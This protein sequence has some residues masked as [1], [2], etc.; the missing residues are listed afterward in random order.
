MFDQS[1]EKARR[2]QRSLPTF[3]YH[4][5]FLELL[6]FIDT[7]YRHV[8]TP[9]HIALNGAFRRLEPSPQR[10]Y[11]RLVNRKGRIFA[12]N[13]LRYPEIGDLNSALDTLR[14]DDWVGSPGGE[15]FED[16]LAFLTKDEI[17]AGLAAWF[18]GMRRSLRKAELIEFAM[19]NCAPE[20]FMTRVSLD[21]L[22]VQRQSDWVAFL[23][24]LYFG[25]S[26]DSLSRFTLRDMGLVRTHSF[27]EV[28]EPRFA[29]REEAL[30][31]FFYSSRLRRYERGSEHD[32]QTV[33]TTIDEWPEPAYEGAAGLRDRL[34][35]AIGRDLERRGKPE[36]ARQVYELGDS[37]ACTERGIRLLLAA[38]DRDEAQRRLEA[39]LENPRS[40][41]ERLLAS[42]LL[43]RKFG[44][45]RTSVVTDALRA[46][47]TIE[48][49]EAH[50]GA[51]DRGAIAHCEQRG[52]RAWRAENTLWRTLFGL[53][54]W[55]ELFPPGQAAVHSPF[56]DAPGSLADGS[57]Y[58]DNE[59]AIEQ[60]LAGLADTAATKRRLLK[61]STR[62]FGTANGIFRWRRSMAEVVFALIDHAEPAPVA[63][64][65]R[66][67]SQRYRDTRDGF[68]DL[69]VVDDG[70]ARLVEIKAQGDQLRRN[71]LN[72][73]QQLRDAGLNAEIV[74]VRWILDP[75]QTYVVVDVETTGGRGEAHRITELAAVKLRGD[76]VVDRFQSLVNPL[77]A[78]PRGIT[79]LTGITEE[80]VNGAPRFADLADD[81]EAFMDDA[82]FVAHNVN[83]DYGFVSREY[84]RLGR[85][86][87]HAK[88]CTCASM[89]KLYPG[90]DS[91]SL[92]ALCQRFDIPLKTHHRALCDAE[93]AAELLLL[94][95]EKRREALA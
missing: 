25:E 27:R 79:R 28:Y 86:F 70:G 3:Y 90:G 50:A 73:L 14:A 43:A 57:F 64:M 92:A 89:R 31:T 74:R 91:Y 22:L 65:L 34:A 63:A 9:A 21:R 76:Q 15:F 54:F 78:I 72:R 16:V 38:G 67:M 84:A 68:P 47:A 44:K 69:L 26:R 33:T 80:M 29:D 53:L 2:P 40:E 8:L 55:E 19:T 49:D 71:Q 83:F 6:D 17:C 60:R 35:H 82:I 42:D 77:R 1:P 5:H 36:E 7:H 10:L 81:F 23:L 85:S 93:A 52:A 66:I 41:D 45:K 62:H 56:E 51:A 59:A 11:V 20:E 88:L 95:N 37:T 61:T 18:P 46:A 24:F 12:R 39:C 4:R 87:R 48:L 32:R 13:R 75:D 94:V 58:R 30:Q